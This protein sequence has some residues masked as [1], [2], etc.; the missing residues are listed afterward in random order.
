V[1]EWTEVNVLPASAKGAERLLTEVVRP[2]VD[3][4]RADFDRWHFF[5]EPELRLRFRWREGT[6]AATCHGKVTAA[7]DQARADGEVSSWAEAPYDGEAKVYGHGLWE[8]VTADWMSGSEL[9]LALIEA[10]RDKPEPRAWYW[11]RREHLFAN[12]LGVPEIWMLLHEGGG[13]LSMAAP[14]GGHKAADVLDAIWA[15]LDDERTAQEA[16]WHRASLAR[17][18]LAQAAAEGEAGT[19]RPFRKKRRRRLLAQSEPRKR[20]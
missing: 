6:S 15:Y 7:L 8:A 5:W 14:W 11:S 9:A 3:A 1:S 2:L 12:E 10:G 16:S 4:L 13:R 17:K 18:L 19:P 20:S